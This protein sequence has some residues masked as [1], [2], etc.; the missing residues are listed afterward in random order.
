MVGIPKHIIKIVCSALEQLNFPQ[1]LQE[2]EWKAFNGCTSLKTVNLP[3]LLDLWS[4]DSIMF[5]GA[6]LERIVFDEGRELIDGYALC[7]V[8]SHAEIIIPKSVKKISYWPM[9]I[10]DQASIFFSG[11][12]PELGDTADRR[13]FGNATIYYDPSTSGWE[14]CIWRDFLTV[15]PMES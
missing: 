13:M 2:I 7:N 3:P 12:C 8:M 1:T 9:A 6:T 11:D 4:M 10:V 14:D 5:P 15:L